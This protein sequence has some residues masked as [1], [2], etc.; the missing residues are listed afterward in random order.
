MVIFFPATCPS[1]SNPTNGM[2]A[3]EGN[4]EGDTATYTCNSGFELDGAAILTC[5]SNGMWDNPPP[6]CRAGKNKTFTAGLKT[7]YLSY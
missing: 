5:Q 1:L 3:A 4:C 6:M 7:H 2:V